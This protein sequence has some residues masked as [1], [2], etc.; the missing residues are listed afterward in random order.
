MPVGLC[1]QKK[2]LILPIIW[3]LMRRYVL[4]LLQKL[5]SAEK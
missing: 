2:K 5:S 4:N 1:V 3:Q